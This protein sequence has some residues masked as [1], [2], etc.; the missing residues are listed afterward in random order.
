MRGS[1][2]V[3]WFVVLQGNEKQLEAGKY[4]G[5]LATSSSVYCLDTMAGVKTNIAPGIGKS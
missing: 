4:T 2:Q 3:S 1:Y 5:T